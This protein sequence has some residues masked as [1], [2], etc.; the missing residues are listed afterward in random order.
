MVF[1]KIEMELLRR[2]ERATMGAMCGVIL[3]DRKKIKKTN[4]NV[5]YYCTY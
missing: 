5:R 1:E 3:T 4:T 2:T